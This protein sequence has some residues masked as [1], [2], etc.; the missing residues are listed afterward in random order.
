MIVSRRSKRPRR[1]IQIDDGN[2]DESVEII[3]DTGGESPAE[4]LPHQN[5]ISTIISPNETV[6]PR[7]AET[8]VDLYSKFGSQTGLLISSKKAKELR[9]WLS[10]ALG[11]TGPRF[12]VLTGPPGC[13]KSTA[14]RA[15]CKEYNCGIVT[16]KAPTS[17][18][19]GVT[20]M[21]LDDLQTF[22]LG[23]RYLA[24]DLV[25][26]QEQN[27]ALTHSFSDS[28]HLLLI[29]DFPVSSNDLLQFRDRLCVI[30]KQAAKSAAH[31][32]VIILSDS[33]KGIARTARLVLGL[34]F[35]DSKNVISINIP[36][37]TDTVMRK[38]LREVARRQGLSIRQPTLDAIVLASAGDFR[39]ALN[40]MQFSSNICS[41]E[42]TGNQMMSNSTLKR[43]KRSRSRPHLP[44]LVDI[45]NIGADATLGTYHAVS[46]IL[47]NK[48]DKHGRSKYVVENILE[49]ARVEASNILEF[50][51]HNY[52][53]FFG[54]FADVVSVLECLSNADTLLPW[55]PE[56]DSRT[57]LSECAA[58]VATRGF[59]LFNTEPIRSGWRPIKGPQSY[60]VFRGSDE[61][62]MI[63]Q[64]YLRKQTPAQVYTQADFCELLPMVER[65]RKQTLKSWGTIG[66]YESNNRAIADSAD[67][68]MVDAE[69]SRECNNPMTSQQLVDGSY[70]VDEVIW[71]TEVEDIEEWD[72]ND[73]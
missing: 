56:D 32:T 14:M 3:S 33:S 67:I 50:L 39:A 2:S 5:V 29:D 6:E 10:N 17:G 57:L 69:I 47:N 59:L 45:D 62:K 40:S 72:D 26:E 22:I 65:M 34:E 37:V 58:L 43:G 21:L 66:G 71:P 24:F 27:E 64:E 60:Q 42:T 49:E 52:S 28:R 31:P 9:T 23:T 46:K 13:G 51:H 30:L 36:A 1:I 54:N 44:S 4:Q 38:Q 15:I 55:R 12:L 73:T 63:A 25:D 20:T 48:R 35:V 68:A 11:R 7:R 70:N 16:W 53:E 19:H 18:S 41:F 8:W 61:H